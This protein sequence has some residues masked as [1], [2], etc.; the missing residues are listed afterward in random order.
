MKKNRYIYPAVFSYDSDGISISFPDL[1]GCITCGFTDEEAYKNANEAL[2][3]HLYGM[4]EDSDILPDASSI[5]NIHVEENECVCLIEVW[6]I[7]IRDEM[8]N[9]AVKKTL[10][11]PKWLDDLALDKKVNYSMILQN[12][13]KSYLGVEE[14][15]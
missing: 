10:T 6:M 9:K 13:L 14:R 12:G 15:V 8:Q 3:L 2:S 11:I 1:P 4:E 5:K 7:P